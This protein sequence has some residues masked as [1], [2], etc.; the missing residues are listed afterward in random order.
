MYDLRRA[1]LARREAEQAEDVFLG[2]QRAQ[3]ER[4]VIY[5]CVEGVLLAL[6]YVVDA[7][8]DGPFAGVGVDVDGELL[9]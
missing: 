6:Q 9:A 2:E 7:L 4:C 3:V 1:P 5:H 8:F